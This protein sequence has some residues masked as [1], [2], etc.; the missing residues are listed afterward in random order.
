MRY[1]L[2]LHYP[3]LTAADLGEPFGVGGHQPPRRAL[4]RPDLG[5]SRDAGS[6]PDWHDAPPPSP[7]W[8]VRAGRCGARG[9]PTES[10]AQADGSG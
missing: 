4:G 8:Q 10:R 9:D 1:T 6:P 2:F 7:V 5:A 3:E